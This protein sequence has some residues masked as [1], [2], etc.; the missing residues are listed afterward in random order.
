MG[1]PMKSHHIWGR[2]ESLNS[3]STSND[4]FS[5]GPSIEWHSS[6]PKK[7]KGD[8]KVVPYFLHNSFLPPCNRGTTPSEFIGPSDK[9]EIDTTPQSSDVRGFVTSPQDQK[10]R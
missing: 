6:D 10:K 2:S 1:V 4:V 3:D 8:Q 7:C 5:P 9:H